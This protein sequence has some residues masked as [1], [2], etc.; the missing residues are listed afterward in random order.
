MFM[1]LFLP[2]LCLPDISFSHMHLD[3]FG[4]LPSS[5]GFTYLLTMFDRTSPW[6][7]VALL[8]SIT[9]ESC[10]R[11][12]LFTWVAWFQSSLCSYFGLW[13]SIHVLRLVQS[14]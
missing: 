2:S 14:L 5:H 3:L 1:L 10:V 11:A 13:N 9:V 7:E 12:F 4:S 8:S 6:P